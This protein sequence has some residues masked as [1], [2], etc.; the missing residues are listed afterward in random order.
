MTYRELLKA[1]AERLESTGNDNALFDCS[2]LLGLAMGIDIRSG[3]FESA[4]DGQAESSVKAKFEELCSRR[5]NGEPLQY[6]LGEWEFYGIPIK[7]GKGVL[8]PRQDTETLVELA[9]SKCKNSED[10]VIADL[11]SGSGCIA[12]ALE[13]YLRCR[14]VYAVEKSE[15]AT[16]YLSENVKMNASAI[17][18][19]MGDVLDEGCAV[20]IPECDLIVCNPPYLTG[21]DMERLQREVTHEP[22][23]ALFGG[24]DGLDFYRAV[25]R[26][27]KN[28]LKTGGTL[29]YEIGIGQ[30]DDVMQ[31]MVQHG[32]ENVRCKPDPCGIMRCVIGTK[33]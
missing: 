24:E 21:E 28:R 16:G 3:S 25:T 15:A 23:E 30:E 4:L 1:Q 9:V 19:V 8:I 31:I 11:C 29:I 6:L 14:E 12:L 26:I 22:S 13:K 18:L 17:K 33:K 32:F 5:A 27:W 2:E 20:T 7:V 10:I